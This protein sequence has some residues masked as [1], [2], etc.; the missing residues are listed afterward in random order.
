[1]TNK[2]LDN[3]ELIKFIKTHG[4]EAI[5]C[6][7]TKLDKKLN[8]F[9]AKKRILITREKGQQNILGLGAFFILDK[10]NISPHVWPKDNPS[11]KYLLID[12]IVFHPEVRNKRLIQ[13]MLKIGKEIF[14]DL[15]YI[16]FMR[17]KYNYKI[18]VYNINK[19]M[20]EAI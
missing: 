5:R 19:F 17:R 20:K 6:S 1:M 15:K 10:L 12:F 4:R 14:P 16:A 7:R 18:K 3:N 13:G 8:W 2:R 11:G 9:L